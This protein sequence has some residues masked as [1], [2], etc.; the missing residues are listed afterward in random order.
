[1]EKAASKS[2]FV[3]EAVVTGGGS[4]TNIINSKGIEAVD[5]SV[6]MKKVHS[7]NEEISILD[8]QNA[9]L[10]LTAIIENIK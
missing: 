3:F 1:M 4:D 2:G 5:I 9:V 6:G 7:V 10:F 8:M